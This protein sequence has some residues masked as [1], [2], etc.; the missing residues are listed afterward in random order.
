MGLMFGVGLM[1]L[2]YLVSLHVMLWLTNR[3]S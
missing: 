2:A 3:P 1:T